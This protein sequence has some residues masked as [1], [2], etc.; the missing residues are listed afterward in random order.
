MEHY[1]AGGL[2]KPLRFTAAES[3]A[4]ICLNRMWNISID[5]TTED[6]SDNK[7]INLQYSLNGGA[8]NKYMLGTTVNL[9][10][11]EYVEFKALGKNETISKGF[12]NYYN[13]AIDKKVNASGNIQSLLVENGFKDKLDVPACCYSYMFWKCTSLQTAP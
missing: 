9:D 11:N 6:T 2:D 5:N 12:Y 7:P 8:W 4:S 13:F 10:E 1:S 3:G